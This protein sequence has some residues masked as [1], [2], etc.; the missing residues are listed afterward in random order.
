MKISHRLLAL[1]GFSAAGLVCVAGVSY[2]AVTSIQTDLRGLTSQAAP[3]QSKTYELQERTER[4]MGRLLKLSLARNTTEATQAGEA[5][6]GDLKAIEQL[7]REL[8][9]LDPKAGGEAVD[10]R[11]SQAEIGKA[12]AQRLA[13]TAA[14]QKET[15]AARVALGKAEEAISA[16][17]A[18]VKQIGVEAGKTADAA[19]DASRRLSN[20]MK[21]VLS[22]QSRLK[23]VAIVVAE[24]DTV[25]NRF[26]LNPLKE[27]MKSA[28]DGIVRLTPETAG[29]DPLKETRA[30]AATLM[31]S[32]AKDGSGL[33]ALRANVLASKPDAAEAYARQRKAILDPVEAAGN[34]LNTVLD[35]TEV[36]AAKQR[37]ALEAAL[38][39]RNEPG[40]VVVTSEEVSLDIR[41]M[42]GSLRLLMLAAN[43]KEAETAQADIVA[44]NKRLGQNMVA[45]R[46]GLV[47]MGKPQLAGQVDAAIA[48]MAEV[49]GSVD[50]VATA[51]RSLLGSEAAMTASLDK[52]KDT[53]QKQA[54]LGEAQVKSMAARQTEVTAAVD[55]RVQQS[56]TAILGIAALIIVVSA[57]ISWRTVA[58]VTRRLDAAVRVAEAV[59]QGQLVRVPA[60]QGNDETARLMGALGA[61]VQTLTGIIGNIQGAAAQIHT[62]SSEISRGNEDL[63]G[64]T[65][66]QASQLQQTA[67]AVEELTS[68]VRQNADSARHAS[69]L[70]G[71]AS[72]VAAQGGQLVG[73]V[74]HTMN[75]IEASSRQI[76]EIV[77]VIDGIAFQTNIL[78]L[79]AAVEAARAG[80]HGRGFAVVASEV[81]A[82]A[83]KSAAAAHQVKAIVDTSVGKIAAGSSQVQQAGNAVQGIVDQ[84]RSV[85]QIIG[86]IA[87]ASAEQ[88]DSVSAVGAA[89][90][91]LDALTQQNAALAEQ[92]TAAAVSLRDQ[93]AGL[94]Q[95][96]AA[97][98]VEHTA[99]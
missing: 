94:N 67:A 79:N 64:R 49:G 3:L 75:D 19:Q 91:Q 20:T 58:T 11:A 31:D 76:G 38:R 86:E 60:T 62:G 99:S 89:V 63:S 15:E 71:E 25:S 32:F 10:F 48:R 30:L 95:A 74:V 43:A 55:A 77:G 78:A 14:Y 56:L 44:L 54:S 42:V 85:T 35:N 98:H 28:V 57:A 84:V 36:Q 61:M 23:E 27:K 12:V 2:F 26:R 66:Q 29:D 41:E 87:Q 22:A 80:E 33:L 37:Q 5:A 82:L 90:Q 73:D 40:G 18:S 9:A 93:A 6:E 24:A 34:K 65:E 52:L 16:T 53:A 69:A 50:K 81:R 97:F 70:A 17:R 13:D 51:K 1:S 47:K 7:R 96:V 4:A 21:S 59:S 72:A 68:T 46:A 88:A 8:V 92:S 39:T 83:Q 45:M